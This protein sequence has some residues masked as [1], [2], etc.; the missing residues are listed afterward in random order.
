MSFTFEEDQP[1]IEPVLE[2]AT[3]KGVLLF[4]AA[5]NNR[6][7]ENNP[8]GYPAR[9]RS[10][11]FCINSSDGQGTKS[12][13]SPR[14]QADRD[15][16]SVVG[17]GLMAAWPLAK[18][19]KE[20]LKVMSGTSC[21]TPIA[22]GIAALILEFARQEFFDQLGH[23]INPIPNA[24][25]LKRVAGMRKVLLCMTDG[26]TNGLYNY[27]RPRKLFCQEELEIAMDIKKALA[28]MHG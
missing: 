1:E 20:R 19:N 12:R 9:V 8:I 18:N 14:G 4:A 23:I 13:F 10:R 2:Y 28:N 11:V 24:A 17:E 16:F 6:A 15:N 5:S 27:I 21:G 7:N 25:S 26:L 22:A 3:S